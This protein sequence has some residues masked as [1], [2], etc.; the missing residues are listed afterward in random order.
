MSALGQ[1]QTSD[2]RPLMSALPPKADIARWQHRR[3]N[4][5]DAAMIDRLMRRPA[6]TVLGA[7]A[8]LFIVYEIAVLI[9]AYSG[10]SYVISDVVALS[11]EVEGPVSVLSVK[12]NDVVVKDAPLF[13]IEPTPYR[14]EVEERTAAVDQAEANLALARD[15]FGEMQAMLAAARAVETDAR[16][17]FMRVQALAKDGVVSTAQLD[18]A[19]R[20]I[21][22][23]VDKTSAA[24]AASNVATENV[25]V[26]TSSRRLATAAL[27]R[28]QYRLSKTAIR[29]PQAGR[30]APFTV[31][32]G[33]YLQV[34]TQV[35]AI[36][37]ENRRRIVANMAERHLSRIHA[38]QR[39][40]VTLGAQPWVLHLGRVTS[41][42]PAIARSPIA[43]QVLPYVAPTTDWIRLPRRFPVEVELDHWPT[44]VP[45]SAGA[46]GRVLIW[47]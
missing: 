28:A 26:V 14:L 6:L 5:H 4:K 34:G 40:W 46:D 2:W 13:I 35:L 39:A 7:C 30:V 29:A 9:F 37:T 47:F 38:G 19:A 25:A 12:D 32:V 44:A 36:V 8:A 41:V 33:D 24:Q 10:D 18:D 16:T 3:R 42:A 21:D 27:A 22:A 43:P 15:H 11:A 23:A 1:N 20:D 17:H 45:T 31:R